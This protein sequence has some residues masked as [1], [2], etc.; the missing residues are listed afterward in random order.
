MLRRKEGSRRRTDG[1]VN[2]GPERL[3]QD[4]P[5]AARVRRRRHHDDVTESATAYPARDG[6]RLG[7]GAGGASRHEADRVRRHSQLTERTG[8]ELVLLG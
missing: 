6:A 2:P 5:G 8:R 1:E 4:Q 3:R 7:P